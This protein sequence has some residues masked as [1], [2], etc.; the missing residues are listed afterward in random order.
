M[1][2]VRPVEP[3]LKRQL[4]LQVERHPDFVDYMLLNQQSWF[5]WVQTFHSRFDA[6][7]ETT[8]RLRRVWRALYLPRAGLTFIQRYRELEVEA[9]AEHQRELE[10]RRAYYRA[11]TAHLEPEPA[12]RRCLPSSPTSLPA[13]TTATTTTTTLR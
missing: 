4:L 13:P 7:R 11:G 9:V 1:A 3:F 10:K 2:E 6:R 5:A 8:K 12:K